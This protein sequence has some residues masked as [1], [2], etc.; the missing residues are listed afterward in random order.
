MDES[1][2]AAAQQSSQFALEI[3]QNTIYLMGLS[4]VLGSMVTLLLLLM[5]DFVRQSRKEG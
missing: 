3:T 2:I 4:F 1:K 5:L